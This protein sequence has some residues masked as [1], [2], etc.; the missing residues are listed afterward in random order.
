MKKLTFLFLV[1][2]AL[3]FSACGDFQDV[4]FSGIEGVRIVKMSQQGIEAE[5]TVRIKNPNKMAFTIYP[6]DMD[7]TLSGMSAGKAHLSSRVRIK[8][9]SEESY[10]FKIKSDF[11]SLSLTDLP[12]L[13]SMAMSKNA[14]VGLKGNLKVGKVF[15]KRSYPVDISQ[16]VPM[17]LN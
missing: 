12:K 3:F 15:V 7:V 9:H 10:T 8:P 16:R 4:S 14:T 5:I 17:N 6:T 2:S 1:F 11:S 13:L